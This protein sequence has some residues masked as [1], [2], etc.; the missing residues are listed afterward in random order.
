MT[1]HSRKVDRVPAS[2]FMSKMT[3][4]AQSAE[5]DAVE[6]HSRFVSEDLPSDRSEVYQLC[7]TAGLDL[8]CEALK[9]RAWQPTPF[10]NFSADELELSLVG[11]DAQTLSNSQEAAAGCLPAGKLVFA[12]VMKTGGLLVDAFFNCRCEQTRA[13]SVLHAD[14]EKDTLGTQRCT[15]PSICTM[16]RGISNLNE[17]CGSYFTSKPRMFTVLRDPIERVWSFYNY[18]KRWYT[19]Y[20]EMDL[21]M[22]YQRLG[23]DLNEGLAAGTGCLFCAGELT[24]AM[25][26]RYFCADQALCEPLEGQDSVTE[27]ILGQALAQSKKVLAQMDSIFLTQDLDYFDLMFN[28]DRRLFPELTDVVRDQNSCQVSKVINH[29]PNKTALSNHTVI[30]WISAKNRADILL[31]KYAWALPNLWRLGPNTLPGQGTAWQAQFEKTPS[32][33]RLEAFANSNGNV[34]ATHEDMV[35]VH[36]S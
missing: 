30:N 6:P 3:T 13:C 20:Q 16:H 7:H 10:S 23:E 12:H 29:T 26:I 25:T 1:D 17:R 5:I 22:I 15:S 18:L 9:D 28:A 24:N 35:F 19:P 34:Q 32:D 31:Y 14:G 21:A 4:A 36:A 8:A 11:R 2:I 33:E 27:D